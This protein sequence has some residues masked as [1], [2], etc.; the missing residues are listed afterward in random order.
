MIPLLLFLLAATVGGCRLFFSSRAVTRKFLVEVYLKTFVFFCFG[1]M[2]IFGFIA[3]IFF[4]TETAQ[5]VGW[6]SGSPFQFEAG[7]ASLSLGLI[8]ALAPLF[9][10]GFWIATIIGNTVWFWGKAISHICYH[11]EECGFVTGN[12]GAYFYADVF[13]PLI[14]L[15]LLL[16]HLSMLQT[17]KK[18]KR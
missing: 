10:E 13:F 4:A 3:N 15:V 6:W 18:K 7:M 8:G 12:A 9:K 1:L 11:I 5:M 16:M 14:S 17:M 2:G